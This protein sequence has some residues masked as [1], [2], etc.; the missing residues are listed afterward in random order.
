MKRPAESWGLGPLAAMLTS[1]QTF[2]EQQKY[3]E[4][5]RHEK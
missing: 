1:G 3:K 2:L 4:T 5:I